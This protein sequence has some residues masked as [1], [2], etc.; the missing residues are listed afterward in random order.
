MRRHPLAT[1]IAMT[2][3]GLTAHHLPM[4]SSR[5]E[6]SMTLRGHIARGNPLWRQVPP[7]SPVLA[8]F[9]GAEHY[10]SPTLYPSKQEHGRAVPTW[11]YSAVHVQGAIGFIHHPQWLRSFVESLTEEHE[12]GRPAPWHVSDAPAGYIEG[13]LAGIVGIEI[14]V[15]AID[16]KVKGS[17][18]RSEADRLATAE[19]LRAEGVGPL[20]VAEIAPEP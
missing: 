7:G 20:D 5:D 16:G 11:N 1:L 18:N 6:G 13:M 14:V 10:I 17:Q 12:Q 3:E 19:A 9:R 15:S 4:L 8:V 2:P